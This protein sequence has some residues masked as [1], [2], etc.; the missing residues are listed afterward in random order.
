MPSQIL[1]RYLVRFLFLASLLGAFSVQAVERVKVMALFPGKAMLQIDGRQHLLKAGQRSPEGVL[2][3]SASASEAVIEVN[4]RSET[5]GLGSQVG[6]TFA[7]RQVVEVRIWA[8]ARGGYRTTGSI[9]GRM[10]GMLVDTGATSVAM[11]EP[12]ARRL[13]IPY[14]VEGEP[15]GVR[16]ASGFARAWSV[17][18]DRVQVGEIV[19]RQVEA[20]V[21]EG[22]SPAQVLLGMS[23][24]GRVKMEQQGTVMVLQS[25]F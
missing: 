13:G 9:N 11:S 24:L 17:V 5:Y 1:S 6:G 8:D 2:L 4:G 22:S 19:L 10:T 14:R 12:E 7:R 18:L 15:S 21:I 23:F 20:V 3:V 16:T 25:R